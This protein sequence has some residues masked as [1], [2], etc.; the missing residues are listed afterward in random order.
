MPVIQPRPHQ[1]S[2]VL[3]MSTY[4]R[5]I[6]VMPTG[7]GKTITMIQDVI[8]NMSGTDQTFVVVAP[9]IALTNQL[10]HEF[11]EFLDGISVMH[12]HSGNTGH[13]T[14]TDP[15]IIHTWNRLPLDI[16]LYSPHIILFV[17]LL[18]VVLLLIPYT[19]MRHTI[20]SK[21]N[22]L[23]MSK[24]FQRL[25]VVVIISQLSLIHI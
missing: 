5:G 9:T 21:D 3:N 17:V 25:R 4:D 8:N 11:L 14:V 6:V 16:N 7:S 13:F 12:V 23:M 24:L 22:G 20:V 1:E 19:L 18:R 15:R 10:S 2:A